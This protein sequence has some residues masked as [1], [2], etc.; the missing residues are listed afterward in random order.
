[1]IGLVTDSNAQLPA[2]LRDR[3]HV[4]V[5]PLTV[6]LDD[7]PY[8]EGVDITT[9]DFYERLG[10][11][12]SVSTAA[13]FVSSDS[14]TSRAEKPSTSRWI[15]TAR[16]VAGRCWSAATKASSIASRSS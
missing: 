15:K 1:V 7:T 5:V 8:L 11:G 10:A 6:V 9:A 4:G 2:D 14:A 12:A 16:C 3:Y 13:P